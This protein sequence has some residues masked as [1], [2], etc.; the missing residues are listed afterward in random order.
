[1]A[2][3]SSGPARRKGISCT[4]HPQSYSSAER[5]LLKEYSAPYMAS[6]YDKIEEEHVTRKP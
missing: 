3:F 6:A 4:G 2:C 5:F 1:M